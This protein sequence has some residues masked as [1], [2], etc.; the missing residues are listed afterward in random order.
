MFSFEVW[1][2]WACKIYFEQISNR[3]I[4]IVAA[5]LGILYCVQIAAQVVDSTLCSLWNLHLNHQVYITFSIIM[6]DF[7]VMWSSVAWYFPWKFG[8]CGYETEQMD[9]STG[10]LGASA[11]WGI[12]ISALCLLALV[13]F[14]AMRYAQPPVYIKSSN[15]TSQGEGCDSQYKLFLQV[16][17]HELQD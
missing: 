17:L 16:F 9:L 11:M 14:G 7:L 5:M 13:V 15:K 10:M 12:T 4:F 1:T 2:I 8:F 3:F 6:T